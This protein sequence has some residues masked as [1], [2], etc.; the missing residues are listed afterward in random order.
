M[1]A[2]TIPA[3]SNE[4]SRLRPLN[5]SRD[6]SVVAD[7]IELCFHSTMDNE[8]QQFIQQM[9]RASRDNRFLRWAPT[10][11]ETTSMPLSGYVWDEAGRIVGNI[12]L[13]PFHN[14]GKRIYLLANVAVHPDFRLRGIARALTEQA[15]KHTRQRNAESIW[16]HVRDDNA[17]ALRLYK[18]MGFQERA[19]RTTWQSSPDHVVSNHDHEITITPRYSRFWPQQRAWLKNLHPDEIIW[20]HTP[21][22]DTFGTGFK[23]WLYRLFVENEVRQWAA[24]KAGNLQGVISWLPTRGQVDPLWPALAPEAEGSVLTALL[25]HARR[26]LTQRRAFSIDYPANQAAQAIAAAGFTQIRTLI[27]MCTDDATQSS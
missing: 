11:I 23:Y 15:L 26:H 8:G 5:I 21:D 7:L 10:A 13:V 9:R 20:Y 2:V 12:S 17:I 27:W 19:R 18:A 14:K 1:S 16:L 4:G 3:L 6:L 25:V 24:Q 22:W